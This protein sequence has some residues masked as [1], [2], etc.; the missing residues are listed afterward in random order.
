MRTSAGVGIAAVALWMV[1]STP[2]HAT[3]AVG[4]KAPGFSLPTSGGDTLRADGLLGK[5][6]LL[7]WFT[8]LCP[9]CT[10]AAPDLEKVTKSYRSLQ[11]VAVSVLGA[12]TTAARQFLARTGVHFP[13]VLDLSGQTTAAWAGEC[14]PNSCPLLSLYFVDSKG[15]VQFATHY[16]GISAA[17]MK[18]Q[19]TALR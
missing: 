18:K 9:G 5:K 8:N 7:V 17:D 12:D 3:V 13:L 19:L 4:D 16:P 10:A 14:P 2:T 1:V 6:P 11:V 15:I